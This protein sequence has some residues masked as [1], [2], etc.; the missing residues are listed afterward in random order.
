MT[1]HYA[2]LPDMLADLNARGVSGEDAR[3]LNAVAEASRM[4]QTGTGGRQF[5]STVETRT[6]DGCGQM[7]LY[8]GDLI[9]LDSLKFDEDGDGIFETT[10]TGHTLWPWNRPSGY[11]AR[12]ID[13]GLGAS[14]SAFPSGVVPRVQIVGKWGHS[15]I[16][17]AVVGATAIT[18]TV[19][20]DSGLTITASADVATS[21]LVAVGDAV[22]IEDE[23]LG[24]VTSVA[25]D[26]L[27]FVVRAR[28]INGT[29]AAAHSAKQLYLRRYPADVERAVRADAARYLWTVGRG[30]QPGDFRETWPAIAEVLDSYLDPAAVI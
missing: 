5:H 14:R 26:G 7:S 13:L 27:T 25:G 6:F 9:S 21:N 15:E 19:A 3:V 1:T 17:Q 16:L 23:Q 18:A 30:A 28:G 29:T 12:R 8:V 22:V 2:R 11:A 24:D 10:V 4:M 20:T